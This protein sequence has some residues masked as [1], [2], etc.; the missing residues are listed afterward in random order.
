VTSDLRALH[1]SLT[2][3]GADL[4]HKYETLMAS[5]ALTSLSSAGPQRPPTGDRRRT[6]R[7]YCTFLAHREHWL[8]RHSGVGA[9]GRCTR[10]S[11]RAWSRHVRPPTGRRSTSH[12]SVIST[13][14]QLS[15]CERSSRASGPLPVSD[16]GSTFRTHRSRSSATVL[17][18]PSHSYP[19]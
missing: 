14:L 1:E 10:T 17:D 8:K 6:A 5:D 16:G 7:E 15:R 18:V 9:L 11:P 13:H 4:R 12:S 2:R 3:Q 19:A